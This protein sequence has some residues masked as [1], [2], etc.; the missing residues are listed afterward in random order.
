MIKALACCC[1]LYWPYKATIIH[2]AI[3]LSCWLFAIV[4]SFSLVSRT[5]RSHSS[6][7]VK[8]HRT[9][10]WGSCKWILIAVCTVTSSLSFFGVGLCIIETGKHLPLTERSGQFSKYSDILFVFSV[11][12]V[13]IKCRLPF[14]R[15]QARLTKLK[16]ISVS[17]LRSCASSRITTW[18]WRKSGSVRHSLTRIPSVTYLI[19]VICR[20]VLSSNRIL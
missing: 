5:A 11:A 20:V 18:Y 17:K 4:T 12:E 8:K 1:G 14:L 2:G 9:S 13:T 7:P 3:S 6:K 19:Y 10:P 16:R 15:L